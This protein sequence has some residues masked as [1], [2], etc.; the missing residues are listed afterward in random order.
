MSQ[1]VACPNC[2]T[3]YNL[4]D[5]A[6][7]KRVKC[8]SCGKPFSAT[9]GAAKAKTSKANK[10]AAKQKV[11][12]SELQKMG[13]GAIKAQPDI[14]AAEV[15]PGPD[16]LRNHVVQDPGFGLPSSSAAEASSS[17]SP[18]SDDFASVTSNPYIKAAPKSTAKK[19]DSKKAK[20]QN[21]TFIKRLLG[22]VIDVA[23]LSA[24]LAIGFFLMISLSFAFESFYMY[25]LMGPVFWVIMLLY[26][27]IM[28]NIWGKT[29]GKMLLGMK[30]V[31]VEGERP[32]PG[33]IFIRML[34]RLIP[35]EQLSF[36]FFKD[37]VAGPTC[38]HDYLADTRVIDEK[39]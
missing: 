11:D 35:Y 2:Q 5:S 10:A 7:G 24:V 28:E 21:A 8:K 1:V 31:T 23:V 25:A 12:P 15:A 16:P 17:D 33:Q 4:P 26:Y 36:L 6:V 20:L 30:V 39:I 22:F 37:R 18:G 34:V 19:S 3:R 14:F 9:V 38:L 29:F 32:S 27:P 13:I